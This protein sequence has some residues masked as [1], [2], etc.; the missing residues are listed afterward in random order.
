MTQDVPIPPLPPEIFMPGPT[1]MEVAGAIAVVSATI[2]SIVILWMFV[3]GLLRK[4]H[5]PPQPDSAA[6]QELRHAVLQLGSEV[7]EL[8]ERLDFAERVL[9]TRNEPERIDRGGT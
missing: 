2:G 6:I 9:A 7:A 1:P 8:Q 4:W 5:T 3:R